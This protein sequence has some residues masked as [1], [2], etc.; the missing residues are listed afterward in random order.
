MGT[1]RPFGRAANAFARAGWYSLLALA[2]LLA[3]CGAGAGNGNGGNNISVSITNKVTTLQAGTAAISFSATVQNDSS[4]S[5]VTWNL[6]ANGT[7]CSP[8]CGTLSL[9]TSSA[10]TYTPPGSGPSAP[11]NQPTLTA[12]SVAKTNKSDSDTFTITPA[13]VVSITNKFM[14]VN[15]GASAFVVNATVQNDATNSGVT[16]ALTAAC[17]TTPCGTLTGA[18]PTSITYTPPSSVTAPPNV[19]LTATAV[20]ESSKSDSDS[21]A[22]NQPAITVA[23][24]NKLTSVVAGGSGIFFEANA[25]ND[26]SNAGT[27]W[28]LTVSGTNCEPT[29]GTLT[30]AGQESI[31]YNPP[32]SVPTAPDNKPT[33]SAISISDSTKSDSDTFTIVA[34]PPI[35]VAVTRFTSVLANA[36]GITFSAHV[37]NDLSNPPKGVT[38]LLTAGASACSPACGSLSNTTTTATYTPPTSV[39]SAPNNQ[40]TI[41]ATSVAD[42]TKTGSDTFTITST[43]TNSC[44]GAPSG[45][46]SLLNGH[47]AL[48]MEG[49]EGSGTG[50]PLLMA[51]GFS[52][53]GSGGISGGEE[54]INDTISPQH[55]TIDSTP[56]RSLYTVGADHRGCLQLTNAGGTTSVFRFGLGGINSGIASKGRVTEFDDSSGNGQ[57]SR[58]SGILRLQDPSAFVLT[59]LQNQYAFGVGGWATQDNQFFRINAAGWFSN[60]SGSLS[61]GVDDLNFAGITTPDTRPLTGSINPVSP[62]TGR[63]TGTFDIFN[64]AIYV[65]NASELFVVGIDPV[66]NSNVSVGRV[67]ATG[68]FFTASSLSGNYVVHATGSNGDSADVNLDLLTMAPGGAQ[69]GTL[70]GTVYSYGAG[71]GAQTS[72]LSGVTYNVDAASGRTVLGNPGDNLPILYV[73]TPTDGI[74]AFVVGVGADALFGVAEPQTSAAFSAGTYIFG[75]E[76]P[77]DNTVANRAGVAQIASGGAFTG[78]YDQSTTSALPQSGQAIS[79]TV[80]LGPNGTGNIGPSTVAITSGSKLFSIDESGGTSGPAAIVVAE[81]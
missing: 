20:H 46:E 65:V 81:Q 24:Q 75:T 36:G 19:T 52:A 15:M 64:W 62:T 27:S 13:L 12:T 29:C 10:V 66:N 79:G 47:Y 7:A 78:T 40:P 63:T 32:A 33:L 5:G 48:L 21:F 70:G 2:V 72:T 43:V 38:W 57:G 58:E 59:A 76:D 4:N 53:N 45:N 25:E 16:W 30:L 73:T 9:A 34:A 50:T 42:P 44:S 80:S 60:S 35:S 3:G 56:G 22:V 49:F 26:T 28:T 74:A 77:S 51:A 67:I 23:I 39:P 55:L 54:D 41:T 69:A 11:N 71:N 6:T 18:T 37:Q 61:N 68:T 8:N 31:V 1:R 17:A 14:S